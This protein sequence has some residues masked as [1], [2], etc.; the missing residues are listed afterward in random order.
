MELNNTLVEQKCPTVA[1]ILAIPI[2]MFNTLA[3]NDCGYGGTKKYLIDNY[4][5]PFF[6]QAKE[7]SSRE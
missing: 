2:A 6:L 1:D 3:A 4:V 5:H 7:K